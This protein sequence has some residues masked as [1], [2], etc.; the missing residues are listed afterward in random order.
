M[1]PKVPLSLE[2]SIIVT[3]FIL[4]VIYL[5]LRNPVRTVYSSNPIKSVVERIEVRHSLASLGL[6]IALFGLALTG[7]F[8]AK[9]LPIHNSGLGYSLFDVGL[10]GFIVFLFVDE[11][12]NGRKRRRWKSV[13]EQTN[14]DLQRELDGIA[15]DVILV[16][17]ASGVAVMS[18]GTSPEEETKAL[19]E[20]TLTRMKDLSEKVDELRASVVPGLFDQAFPELFSKR[21]SRLQ[22]LEIRNWGDFLDPHR[23]GLVIDLE[24]LLDTLETHLMIVAKERRHTD[25]LSQKFAKSYEDLVY[26]DLQLL[27]KRI[28]K[29]VSDGLISVLP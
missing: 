2:I 20:S 15:A 27:L 29:G 11:I 5:G 25:R 8:D 28:L 10:S 7:E 21:A 22:R 3:A 1:V 16:T 18:P 9:W 4:G 19:R 12:L 26:E 13:R 6:L 23:I 17:G 14:L 24:R